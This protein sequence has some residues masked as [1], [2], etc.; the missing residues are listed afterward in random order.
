[1]TLQQPNPGASG[2][3]GAPGALDFRLLFE[4]VPG[5]FLVLEPAPRFT[6]LGAS[7]AYLRVTRTEREKIVGRGVFEVFPDN[8]DDP[9]ATGVA[10]L[11]VSL[12]RI[13]AGETSDAMPVQKCDIR[14]PASE[15]GGFEERYWSPV[16]SAVLSGTGEL[17]YIFHW[18]EDVTDFVRISDELERTNRELESFSYSVSHDLRAPLR[19]ISGFSQILE[20]DCRDQLDEEG[21]RL[22]DVISNNGR[23][24]NQL[25]DD[26]LAFSRL[27]RKPLSTVQIDMSGM[28][29]DV[30]KE[31]H[32]GGEPPPEVVSTRLPPAR[33][34]AALVRK[35]WVNLLSN[36]VKFS[37]KCERPVIEVRGVE[38]GADVVYSVKD[39]GTGFDIRY[40]EKLFGMFQRLHSEEEFSGGGVG[41]AIVQR[42]IMRHGGRVWAESKP[43]EGATFYFSLPKGAANG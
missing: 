8:Q 36:A 11:R 38:N 5:L 6:I 3:G 35:V 14:R 2:P 9:D 15:G 27:G 39:N 37:S 16:N 29:E 19:A 30:L 34:D 28:V 7:A 20:E 22:L 4:M 17:L 31:V 26:L 24:M 1:M 18:V 21:R 32:P 25:I 41:L 42:V 33:G 13:L 10:N 43:Q 23:K 40:S 12:E